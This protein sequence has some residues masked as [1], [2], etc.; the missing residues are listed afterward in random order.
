ASRS[1]RSSLLEDL[2]RL[3]RQEKEADDA[4]KTLKK[5]FAQS[6]KD[7]LLQAKAAR[8][9]S[10]NYVNTTSTLVT[11]ASTPVNTASPLTNVSA[12]GL[13]YPD[14]ATYNNQDDSQIPSL[15]DIYEVSSDGIFTSASSKDEDA[16]ADFTNLESTVNQQ[17]RQGAKLNP[18]RYLK[19]LKIKV[20]LMLY[21]KSCCNSRLSLID[22]KF[23]KKFYKVVNAP[24]GLYQAPRAWDATLSTFLVES[25]YRRGLIDKTLFIKKDKKDIMLSRFQMSSMG[26]LTFF[27]GLLV[28]QTKFGIFIS[29]DKYVAEILNKFD[30]LSVKTASTSIETKKPLVKDECNISHFQPV[31]TENKANKIRGPKEANNNAAKT[32]KKMFA[33]ST[34]DFLLQA[35]AARASSTNYVNTTSTS[36]TTASI[37][38]NTAR[39]LT[40]VSATGPS[41]PDL[42]TYDNQ[43]ASQIPSLEDIYEVSSD[44]IFTSASSKD[45]DAVADFT[46]LES[47]VNIEPKK[48]SQALEDESWVDAIQE[49]LL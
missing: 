15:K 18:K 22:P 9:N 45:E 20:G 43:D 1:G 37:P 26:E 27:L 41:Y 25:G 31:T 10:T 30:F 47:T 11:T 42:S 28:K 3:K 13:S 8:A 4:A 2:K 17:F 38:V 24:Y 49:E 40:N 16:V 48:I 23:L 5:M 44:G 14:L 7:F 6:T 29:Q 12:V 32:L 35:R 33:Q 34:E 46:N 39:P 36:V 19:H 21:R